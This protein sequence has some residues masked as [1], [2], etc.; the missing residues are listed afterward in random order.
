MT[1]FKF[2]LNDSDL[3]DVFERIRQLNG[4]AMVSLW[5]PPRTHL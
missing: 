1:L 4:V 3:L 5:I 2:Q